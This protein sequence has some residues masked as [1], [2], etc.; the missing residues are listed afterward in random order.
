MVM[1]GK[2]AASVTQSM[3]RGGTS[4]F[5]CSYEYNIATTKISGGKECRRALDR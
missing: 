4:A 1:G 3:M 5:L 2:I